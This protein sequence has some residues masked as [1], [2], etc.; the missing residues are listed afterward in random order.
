MGR[1]S[2]TFSDEIIAKLK[3]LQSSF[4]V[5]TNASV[6]KMIVIEYLRNNKEEQDD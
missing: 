4:S 6:V 5:G 2:V 1:V 3:E